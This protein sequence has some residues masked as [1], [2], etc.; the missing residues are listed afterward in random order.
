MANLSLERLLS[1]PQGLLTWPALPL[2]QELQSRELVSLQRQ[3]WQQLHGSYPK[4]NHRQPE[5]LRLASLQPHESYLTVIH[6]RQALEQQL[7][8]P[9]ALHQR[10]GSCRAES[11]HRRLAW[12]RREQPRLWRYRAQK[13]PQQ[14]VDGSWLEAVPLLRHPHRRER[15]RVRSQLMNGSDTQEVLMFGRSKKDRSKLPERQQLTKYYEMDGVLQAYA[16]RMAVLAMICGV[17]AVGA[18]SLFAYVRLQPPVVIRVDNAGEAT[19]VGGDTVKIGASGILGLIKVPASAPDNSPGEVEGRAI[20][21]RFLTNYLTYTPANVERQYAEALNMMTLNFRQLTMNKFR[22][23]DILGKVKADAI[24]S[25]IKI[26]SI[27]PAQGMPWTFQVFAA[28][29]VH[30]LNQ[31]RIEYTEKM[32]CRYQVRLVYTGRSAMNPTGLY[33]GEFWEQQMVGEKDIDLDQKSGLLDRGGEV[34]K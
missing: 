11:L 7:Q 1:E 19:V 33:V 2:E 5:P 29:E 32:V 12:Q 18:L 13:R 28:K 31:Q 3:A 10:R 4:E 22:E 14:Q 8:L 26:R 15:R 24:T 16:N 30:R 9:L 25:S 21:R 17:L 20:T 27:E 34:T 23:E 6:Q